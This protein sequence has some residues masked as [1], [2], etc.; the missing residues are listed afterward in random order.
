MFLIIVAP[1][2]LILNYRFKTK[3][4]KG[5]SEEEVTNVEQMLETIDKL[6]DRVETLEE[7]LDDEHPD[8]RK[9]RRKK[10]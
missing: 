5:I 10:P 3:M 4:I 6:I 2:W 9:Q 8:W 1:L 7:I